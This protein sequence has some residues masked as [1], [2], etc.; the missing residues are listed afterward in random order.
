MAKLDFKKL[1]E[2]GYGRVVNLENEIPILVGPAMRTNQAIFNLGLNDSRLSYAV[3]ITILRNLNKQGITILDKAEYNTLKQDFFKTLSPDQ[4]S[5]VIQQKEKKLENLKLGVT[6]TNTQIDVL[7]QMID[8]AIKKQINN[9]PEKNDSQYLHPDN[10][11]LRNDVIALMRDSINEADDENTKNDIIDIG[12]ARAMYWAN[13]SRLIDNKQYSKT[14]NLMKI[15]KLTAFMKSTSSE[16]ITYANAIKNK[17]EHGINYV[18]D[19]KNFWQKTIEL[20]SNL[21]KKMNK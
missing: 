16:V 6:R 13:D 4:K 3:K 19:A 8:K 12:I 5:N 20:M 21:K 17:L 9:M 18:E 1:V 11:L 15:K 10:N 2:N 7:Y 14:K